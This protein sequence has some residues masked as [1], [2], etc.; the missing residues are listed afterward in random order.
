MGHWS[1]EH[2]FIPCQP[3]PR[4]VPSRSGRGL[5]FEILTA[6][7]GLSRDLLERASKSVDKG[8]NCPQSGSK[9][10]RTGMC[11][12]HGYCERYVAIDGRDA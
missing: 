8:H 5:I 2:G 9:L 3:V 4:P 12:R 11:A 1:P 7:P 6:A 10:L